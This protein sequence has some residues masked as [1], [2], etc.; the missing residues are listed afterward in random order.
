M[1]RYFYYTAQHND[2]NGGLT[3]V[4]G[5]IS[6]DTT[7]FPILRVIKDIARHQVI[8]PGRIHVT[9]WGR[10]SEADYDAFYKELA[11]RN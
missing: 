3:C 1:K 11:T 2:K 10:I 5:A 7:H 4:R 8:E 6:S 9:F